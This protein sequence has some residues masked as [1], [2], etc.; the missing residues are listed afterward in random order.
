MSE[1]LLR[2][3]EVEKE[4]SL[5]RSTIYRQMNAGTFPKAIR[6]GANSVRWRESEI[7]AWKQSR[8]KFLDPD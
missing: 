5:S 1:T 3:P 2:R 4:T 6:V 8:P 7:E